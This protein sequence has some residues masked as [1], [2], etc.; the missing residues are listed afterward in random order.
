MVRGTGCSGVPRD[1]SANTVTEVCRIHTYVESLLALWSLS[2]Y[3]CLQLQQF[4]SM[5]TSL[6]TY[7]NTHIMRYGTQSY[8]IFACSSQSQM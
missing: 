8:R 7:L 4:F 6:T 2:R 1:V 3:D 5:H